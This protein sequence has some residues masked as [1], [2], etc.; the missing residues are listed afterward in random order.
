[1]KKLA[2]GYFLSA[3]NAL[4]LS[5]LALIILYPALVTYP[6]SIVLRGLGWR[7]LKG[8]VGMVGGLYLL[9]L[10]LG[11][12]TFGL[13]LTAF[14]TEGIANPQLGGRNALLLALALWN[15]YSV[16][17]ALIYFRAA[18]D[19]G[20][21][22][23]YASPVS[24]VG[25][26]NIDLIAINFLGQG[27]PQTN[28]QDIYFYVGVGALVISAL[29]SAVAS[30]TIP[31]FT[32]QQYRKSYPALPS[33]ARMSPPPT[34][35]RQ[36]AQAHSQLVVEVIR[37]GDGVIC[38]TCHTLNPVKASSCSKCGQPFIKA[39]SGLR[40]PVCGA[41]FSAT[42]KLVENR[43]LCSQCTSTLS[44]KRAY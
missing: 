37:R 16:A 20:K 5:P 6:V 32:E 40:C 44:L 25:V 15:I 13:I 42:R 43:Y 33:T 29:A 26:A 35:T 17:E 24:L 23:F 4:T 19:L 11:L 30:L 10:L 41:P 9:L 21:R 12:S 7:S 1:M 36:A 31:S 14:L 27:I 39:E 38:K 8:R 22:L 18:R 2:A 3:F 28:V 34:K